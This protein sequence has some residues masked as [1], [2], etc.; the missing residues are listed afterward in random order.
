MAAS[1]ITTT[2]SLNINKKASRNIKERTI[3]KV[4]ER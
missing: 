3:V 4:V 1:E 2:E